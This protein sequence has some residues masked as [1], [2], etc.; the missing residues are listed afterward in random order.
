MVVPNEAVGILVSVRRWKT[1]PL[2]FFQKYP[3]NTA[4]AMGNTTINPT[5]IYP[6][7]YDDV[8]CVIVAVQAVPVVIVVG[9]TVI[10][11]EALCSLD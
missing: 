6:T 11:A 2:L 1:D 7:T 3:A 4:I 9:E 5:I 10:C 8:S